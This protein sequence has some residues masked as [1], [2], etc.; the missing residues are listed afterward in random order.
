MFAT[1]GK[2]VPFNSL[3]IP[4][5]TVH[6][7]KTDR[8]ERQV[9]QNVYQVMDVQDCKQ[10]F[11]QV[12]GTVIL[13]LLYETHFLIAINANGLLQVDTFNAFR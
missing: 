3:P 11:V 9:D 2:I 10:V 8:I 5:I 6:E 12:V 7:P 4:I 1:E 13:K